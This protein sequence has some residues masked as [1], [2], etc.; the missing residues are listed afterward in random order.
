MKKSNFVA[1]V[2]LFS[3][4]GC[5]DFSTN[6]PFNWYPYLDL[7]GSTQYMSF[8]A[9][10]IPDSEK[11]KLSVPY[12]TA[13]QKAKFGNMDTFEEIGEAYP[14]VDENNNAMGA[15]FLVDKKSLNP[16]SKTD[17]EKLTQAKDLDYYDFGKGRIGRAN[18]S[19]Q[20][21]LCK[22]FKSSKGVNIKIATTYYEND[23]NYYASQIKAILTTKGIKNLSYDPH[24]VFSDKTIEQKFKLEEQKSG[25]D[26]AERN[27][28]ERMALLH[29]ICK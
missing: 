13:I 29:F 10:V 14:L 21:G 27:L 12:G 24:F 8:F 7:D 18:F 17:A 15:I 9:R 20:N 26:L 25:K 2:S 22:D 1:I 16:Y 6:Q 3:L 19:S 28:I 5:A 4:A 23:K 11:G